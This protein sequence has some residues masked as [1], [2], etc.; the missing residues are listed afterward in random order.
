MRVLLWHGYLLSGSG[1]NLYTANVVR[2]WRRWGHDVLL[3]CQE[4]HAGDF[5]FVDEH[6]DFSAGNDRFETVASGVSDA[7][8]RLRVV[9]PRIGEVLPVYVYDQYE[10]VTAKPFVDLS[11][12]ELDHYTSANI[13]ALVTAI[14]HHRPDVII[15]G[16]EVMGPY[17]A[18]QACRRT[19]SA[20]VAKLHGSALEYAV[21]KQRRYEHFAKEGLNGARVVVGGSRYMIREASSVVP[22]WESR[23]VVINPGCDVD[24]F[25]PRPRR[26]SAAPTVGYVGK[27][28]GSKGVHNLLAALGLTATIK[29]EAV[30][31]GYGGFEHA[32]HELWSALRTKDLGLVRA[33][34][35]RG[36]DRPLPHLLSLLE[37]GRVTGEY[38]ER[39]TSVTL[40]WSGRLEHGPLSEVLPGFDVLVVPS[41]LA[42][43]FGMVAAEAAACGVLP[44]VPRHSGIGEVGEAVEEAL[45]VRRLV[46]FDPDD[47]IEGIARCI[48]A[49]FSLSFE[50][51]QQFSQRAAA[52]ARERWSWERVAQRLLDVAL[53][54]AQL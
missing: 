11:D 20:Y 26:R 35:E 12:E 38:W 29:L 1:S 34:A 25:A 45:G 54:E 47:P 51:R 28:I 50:E 44:I 8:G 53:Q 23:A 43:A 48:D 18:L 15:T 14:E 16:H 9:R 32:L 36:D 24:I 22:G 2:M 52:L 6:G 4:R 49:V 3:L 30:I 27:L 13:R 41:E 40:E 42:E 39:I 21:K 31:V 10:G 33:I 37:S 5:N 17:I 7:T 19:D 46:T